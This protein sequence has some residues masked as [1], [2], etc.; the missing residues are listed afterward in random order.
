MAKK[1]GGHHG[2]KMDRGHMHVKSI[3]KDS[4]AHPS[5]HAANKKMGMPGGF[6]TADTGYCGGGQ[7][8]GSMG[9]GEEAGED[10]GMDEAQEQ[11]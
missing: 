6:A 3:K 7:P 1:K 9:G 5:H 2:E 8:S 4:M 10:M 11:E